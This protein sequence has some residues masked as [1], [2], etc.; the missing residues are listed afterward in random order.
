MASL[1]LVLYE[2]Q[3]VRQGECGLALAAGQQ[4][5]LQRGVSI[6]TQPGQPAHGGTRVVPVE[7]ASLL[8]VLRAALRQLLRRDDGRGEGLGCWRRQSGGNEHRGIGRRRKGVGGKRES[9]Q[10]KGE[11]RR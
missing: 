8:R 10:K 11:I 2:E 3:D 7:A 6:V 9:E 5:L 1:P 4:V